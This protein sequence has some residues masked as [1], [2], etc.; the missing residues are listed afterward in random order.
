MHNKLT[1][2]FISYSYSIIQLRCWYNQAVDKGQ[3]DRLV[4]N[5]VSIL[6]LVNHYFQSVSFVFLCL[7][8]Q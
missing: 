7:K 4:I 3:N 1:N 2:E 5:R 8:Q 6:Q